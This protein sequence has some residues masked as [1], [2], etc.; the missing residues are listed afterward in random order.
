MRQ[1]R[2]FFVRLRGLFWRSSVQEDLSEEIASHI[3]L[4]TDEHIRAGVEPKEARRRAMI[5]FGG[6]EY[7]KQA[8]REQ[9]R[10]PLLDIFFYDL[11]Y[12]T[13]SFSKSPVFTF[14]A[15]ATLAFGIGASTTIFTVAQ[16]ILLRPLPYHQPDRLLGISEVDRLR[17]TVGSNV[18]SADFV[19]WKR[20]AT[21]FSGVAG[22]M[23]PDERGKDRF[24]LYLERGGD[25]RVLNALSVDNNVFD[26]LGVAPFL[27]RDLLT[28]DDHVVVLSYDCWQNLFAG[29][30][31]IVRQTITLSGVARAVVG[32]MPQGFFFP[33]SNVQ[34]YV[35]NGPFEANRIFHDEGV[36]ARLKPGVSIEQARAEMAAVGTR[37]Q[38]QFPQ[39]N[40][41]LM[42]QVD[43]LHAQFATTSRPAVLMV[44]CAV[45]V[46]FLIVCSNVAHLQLARAAS[47]VREFS[48]RKALGASRRRVIAQLMT[49][50]L[51]LSVLGGVLGMF[52]ASLARG[53]WLHF[54]ASAIPSYA[55]LRVDARVIAFN[56]AITL[57][58]PLLFALGPAWAATGTEG[59]RA[60]GATARRS[61]MRA[62]GWLVGTEVALSVVLVV[63]AGLFIHS[64]VRLSSVDLGFKPAHTLSFR[65]QMAD[66]T[67]SESVGA[68]Q[69]AEIER[70]LREQPGVE[71]VGATIRPV[72]G[73]GSGGEAP[74]TINGREQPL[75][76]EVVTSGYFSAMQ[77]ALRKGRVPSANDTQK[78]ALVLAVNTAFEQ[79]YFPDGN[80]VGRQIGFGALGPATIVGVVADMKQEGVDQ[81][82]EPAAFVSPTQIPLRAATFMVRGHVDRKTL[83]TEARSVVHRVNPQVP[84]E[85][86]ATLQELVQGSM[87]AQRVRTLVL[88]S[89]ASAALLLAALGLYGVLA[90]S[91]TQRTTEIGIRVALGSSSS[92]LIRLIVM[93]GMRPVLCGGAVGFAVACV[94]SLLIRSLLFGI[95]PLDASTYVLTGLVL[96]GISFWACIIPALRALRVDPAAALRE[97]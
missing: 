79:T 74:V 52:L 70:G 3:A 45:A 59:L 36:V 85:N 53:A 41:N 10:L 89:I 71:A 38:R 94:A 95:A 73:G 17:P 82:A 2:A 15:V 60:H 91:V 19:E 7:T 96:A 75:R 72:M 39:T 1:I 54:V 43:S 65:L 24:E 5:E 42:P 13:R 69:I 6:V 37:L 61:G 18:A 49:E 57:A 55:D 28:D 20:A 80:S 25:T 77:T 50:S 16:A 27:G 58:A 66:F 67:P 64:F 68:Q 4:L 26:V 47:R 34:V 86:V 90:Y 63:C 56:I 9:L 11:A 48:I 23:G 33:V 30:P 88:S 81:A 62:R 35:P 46:L 87:N 78:T 84:L 32:V 76:I 12:A 40:A 97:Q 92:Q 44:L 22:Y 93:D 83:E 51:F 14:F 8:C 21:T 31:N 29:D